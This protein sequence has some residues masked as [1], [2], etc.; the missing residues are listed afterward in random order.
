MV[1]TLI[2]GCGY[3]GRRL[4]EEPGVRLRY[5]TLAAGLPACLAE[6]RQDPP[7]GRPAH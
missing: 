1:D 4:R 7:G 2:I 6:G 3:V 5:P